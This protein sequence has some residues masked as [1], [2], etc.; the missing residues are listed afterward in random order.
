MA[1]KIG[2]RLRKERDQAVEDMKAERLV[3]SNFFEVV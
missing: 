3:M 2:V 1:D